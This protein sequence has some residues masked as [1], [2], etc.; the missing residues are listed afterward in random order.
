MKTAFIL[1]DRMTAMDF[2]GVYDSLTRLRSMNLMPGFAWD[3]CAFTKN[4]VDDRGLRFSPDIVSERLDGYDLIVV[5][6]GLGTR[7]ISSV[8]DRA[9]PCTPGEDERVS[10]G[11][12]PSLR[13]GR[14]GEQMRRVGFKKG[15][16]E[17]DDARHERHH[18]GRDPARPF[19]G[20][21]GVFA[22]PSTQAGIGTGLYLVCVG[23]AAALVGLVLHLSLPDKTISIRSGGFA[24]LVVI[25]GTLVA[26]A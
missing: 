12:R 14:N 19:F 10:R 11:I 2:I 9:H 7:V 21:A 13:E 25:G 1:F 20:L 15:R 5:P 26:N 16:S 17:K 3:I 18:H 8:L 24:V 4:V 22:K 6:G 23:L